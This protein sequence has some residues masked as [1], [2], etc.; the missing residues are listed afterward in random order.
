[1]KLREIYSGDA[2]PVSIE[3][4]PPKTPEGEKRFFNNVSA[5]KSLGPAFCSVTYGAGGATREKSIEIIKRIRNE[6]GLTVMFHLTGVG[7]TRAEVR[8]ILEEL[9]AA[10]IDNVIALRG[11]PPKGSRTLSGG[12][13]PHAVDLV[14]EVVSFGGFSVAVAGFPET[15]PEA[16]SAE[17]DIAYLKE[18]VDAGSDVI[19]TQLFFDNDDYF[20][21]VGRVRKAGIGVPIV[22][23]ILPIRSVAQ[24]KRI[25]EL[26]RTSIPPTVQMQAS[27]HGKDDMEMRKFGIEYATLQCQGL[28]G[29][30]APGLHF[31]SLNEPHPL[32]SIVRNLGLDGGAP[33][34]A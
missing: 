29:G 18:K 5:F 27:I 23:G 17:A 10:G 21:F 24:L 4:F 32:L 16:E 20:R 30:G 31:F 19:I 12:D 33:G 6:F 3:F 8:S 25:A 34:L 26:C 22:P 15:H 11:D 1:M 14:R 28:M 9:S 13:F 2:F 7:Q